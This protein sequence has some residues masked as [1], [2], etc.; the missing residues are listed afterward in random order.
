MKRVMVRYRV[1][2]DRAEENERYIRAV[3]EELA[4]TKPAGLRYASFKLADGVSFVHVAQV[5]TA[6]GKNPLFDIDAFKAFS[7]K[8]EDRC[9]EKPESTELFAVGDYGLLG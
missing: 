8:I 4:R 5:D 3:F 7:S 6:D 9:E 2:A 1:K